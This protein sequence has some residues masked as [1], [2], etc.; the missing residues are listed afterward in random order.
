MNKT[1]IIAEVGVNHD[2]N[3]SK[4]I[5]LIEKASKAGADIVKFQTYSSELLVTTDANKANYQIE[6]TGGNDSQLDMLRKLELTS[7]DHH[8]LYKCC[9]ENNVEFLSTAFDLSSIEFLSRIGLQRWKIPSGEITNLPYL[10][11]IARLN[12]PI[13][14]STGMATIA[15]IDAAVNVLD[16]FGMSRNSIT[17]L[18][19]TTDY[20]ASPVSVNLRAMQSIS[21]A[22]GVNVGY[23]DHTKGIT[24]AI[25]SVALGASIVEKHI[26]L[27]RL[28][29]GPDHLASIEPD[30]FQSMVKA[31]RTVELAMG[32]GVKRPCQREIENISCSRKSIVACAVINKGDIFTDLNLTTKRPGTG[33]SPMRWDEVIGKIA[34]R[35]FIADELIEL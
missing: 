14:M 15:D 13:I 11:K 35:R 25:A 20:P 26:T 30:E 28:S 17:L 27:D 9:K 22:F 23:S 4:A 34:Q 5:Q 18:Q 2:G 10:K 7:S 19:C 31:I 33:V 16:N 8:I 24:V 29:S 3:I 21:Q 1:L 32:D 6:R 12:Q